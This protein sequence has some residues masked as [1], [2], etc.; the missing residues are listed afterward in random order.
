MVAL[1]KAP[2]LL[3]PMVALRKDGKTDTLSSVD[4]RDCT[5]VVSVDG[6]ASANAGEHTTSEPI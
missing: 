6:V 1:R 4:S 3:P 2:S 5:D